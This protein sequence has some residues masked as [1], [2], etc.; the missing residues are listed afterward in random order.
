MEKNGKLYKQED[1]PATFYIDR[2]LL[3]KLMQKY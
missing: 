3:E 1:M 2:L